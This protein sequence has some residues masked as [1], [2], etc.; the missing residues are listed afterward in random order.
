MIQ[1]TEQ[2]VHIWNKDFRTLSD[3]PES[4]AINICG[5]VTEACK[6]TFSFLFFF[7]GLIHVQ[8]N[9][10]VIHK[11]KRRVQKFVKKRVCRMHTDKTHYDNRRL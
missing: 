11:G 1:L 8:G 4:M 2:I 9:M 5:Y 10:S 7:G 6:E 3:F